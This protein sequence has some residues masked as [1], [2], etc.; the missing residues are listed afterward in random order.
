MPK[1]KCKVCGNEFYAKPYHLRRGWGKYCS[2]E[3]HHKTMRD[4]KFVKCNTCGK[5]IWRSFS[6]LKHS[7]SGKF[8]CGKSCQTVWRNKFF[9]GS[10][11]S[12][13]INGESI[14]RKTLERSKRR[15]ICVLCGNKDKR[16][17]AVHHKDRNREN[18]RF[19]NLIW[20]CHNCHHLVHRFNKRLK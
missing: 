13:W 6:L 7:K 14:G 2:R 3:C 12:N 15:V 10:K 1:V 19:V 16:I 11:H 17:L 8:F 9:S 18:N 20:L 4:G 5:E